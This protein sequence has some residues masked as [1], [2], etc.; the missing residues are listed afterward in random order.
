MYRP[1]FWPKDKAGGPFGVLDMA[2]ELHMNH[3]GS[4]DCLRSD[5]RE[6][7]IACLQWLLSNWSVS[8]NKFDYAV[9]ELVVETLKEQGVGHEVP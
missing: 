6:T 7:Y 4:S 9:R 5:D 2:L 3:V 1:E 8:T